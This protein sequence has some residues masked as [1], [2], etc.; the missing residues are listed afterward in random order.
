MKAERHVTLA[1]A[2]A[3]ILVWST[4]SLAGPLAPTKASQVV[5]LQNSGLCPD[6]QRQVLGSRIFGDASQAGFSIPE[7][8]VLVVTG[9]VVT[10]LSA[11]P[12]GVYEIDL[13]IESQDMTAFA[14][15]VLASGNAGTAQKA[16]LQ[17][18]IPPGLVVK[19]GR[20]LCAGSAPSATLHANVFGFLAP[21]K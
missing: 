2:V 14:Q 13:T 20:V 15:P 9:A 16:T 3:T 10:M 19:P 8:Q 5:T 18:E 21:D 11:N 17:L 12:I 6:G 1:L 7:G 4:P